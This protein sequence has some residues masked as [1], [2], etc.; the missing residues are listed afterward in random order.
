MEIRREGAEAH[1]GTLTQ[2]YT[3]KQR[4]SGDIYPVDQQQKETRVI[5]TSE[6]INVSLD[7]IFNERT[8]S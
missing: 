3:G 7:A 4:I 1:A 8:G 2:R 6:P 5:V